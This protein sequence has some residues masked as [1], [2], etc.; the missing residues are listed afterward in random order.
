[1]KITIQRSYYRHG[2]IREE[3]LLAGGQPH[4][5]VR[6]WHPNGRM[7]SEASLVDGL[8][9]GR[10]RLCI[11]D[12]KLLRESFYLGGKPVSRARYA[13]AQKLDP[14]LPHYPGLTRTGCR[15]PNIP[16][17]HVEDLYIRGLLK[18][19]TIAEAREWLGGDGATQGLKH[20][21]G[22]FRSGRAAREFVDAVYTAGATK[23]PIPG[24]QLDPQR[25]K[26]A[27]V[28][29]VSLATQL[30][31]RRRVRNSCGMAL[32]KHPGP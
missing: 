19:P 9:C 31:V 2:Q 26:F 7:K 4:G 16:R 3:V 12:G 1:M 11:S 20:S 23:V 18:D 10:T 6:S 8:P 28:I 17:R 5:I 15:K 13:R 25:N 21:L 14:A 22:R 30:T 29:L 32:R 24:T 27:E